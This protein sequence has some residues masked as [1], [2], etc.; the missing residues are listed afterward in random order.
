MI[1]YLGS[2]QQ[3]QKVG[4]MESILVSTAGIL[5]RSEHTFPETRAGWVIKGFLFI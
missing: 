5:F 1:S 4:E 3:E 2:T